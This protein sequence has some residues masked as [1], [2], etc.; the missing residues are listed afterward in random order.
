MKLAVAA[1]DSMSILAGRRR[2]VLYG[3][4]GVG[5]EAFDLAQ[6]LAERLQ[7][8]ELVFVD[9]QAEN[10][11]GTR[12]ILRFDQ[13]RPQDAVCVTISDC[14]V[15]KSLAARCGARSFTSLIAATAAVSPHAVI[16][17]G[18]IIF[19]HCLINAR[20]RVGKHFICLY[21]SHVSHDCQIGDFV[22]FG[23]RVSCCGNVHIGDGAFI[24]AGAILKNGQADRPLRI[25]ARA[26]VGMGAVVIADVPEDAVVVGNPARPLVPRESPRA[27]VASA[28]R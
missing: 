25:G 21:Y 19:D 4:G 24:G 10:L 2:L 27:T 8:E 3:S 5:L 22:T 16:E 26:V 28:V 12:P 7:F 11:G 6:T 13:L 9:D 1:T 17:E 14:R 23:P 18:A 15:R 20:A